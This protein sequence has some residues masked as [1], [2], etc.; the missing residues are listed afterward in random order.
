MAVIIKVFF[1]IS[2]DFYFELLKIYKKMIFSFVKFI[3]DII[4][5]K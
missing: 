2:K 5:L 1:N 3:K 4:I